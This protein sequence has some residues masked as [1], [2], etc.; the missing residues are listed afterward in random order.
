MRTQQHAETEP[1]RFRGA[2]LDEAIG[3][4]EQSL[5]PRTRVVAANHIRRGGIGGFF[6]SDLGVEVSVMLDDETIEEALDRIVEETAATERKKWRDRNDS[7]DRHDR[8]ETPALEQAHEPV[9]VA[10]R[11]ADVAPAPTSFAAALRRVDEEIVRQPSERPRRVPATP[12]AAQAT[13]AVGAESETVAVPA[14]APAKPVDPVIERLEAAFASL[15]S[16]EPLVAIATKTSVATPSRRQVELVVAATDQ[17]IES[18]ARRGKV[19]QLSVRVV[20]RGSTGAEI[21][22]EARWANHDEVM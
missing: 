5:G 15:R 18:I 22:A 3:L 12:S 11:P 14:V 20:L 16:G 6:A 17:L 8:P 19:E 1:L 10:A 7:Q 13:P 2:T 21:E 4:A 9:V